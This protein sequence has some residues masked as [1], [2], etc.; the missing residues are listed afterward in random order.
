[1]RPLEDRLARAAWNLIRTDGPTAPSVVRRQWAVL[2]EDA[3]LLAYFQSV[4]EA[5]AWQEE[6]I[7]I[8]RQFARTRVG[9]TDPIPGHPVNRLSAVRRLL[10]SWRYWGHLLLAAATEPPSG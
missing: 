1:M 7:R 2:A 3:A 10:P 5:N 9:Y 6:R 4:H 8:G